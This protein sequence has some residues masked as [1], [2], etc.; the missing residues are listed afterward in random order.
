MPRAILSFVLALAVIAVVRAQTGAAYE[1]NLPAGFPRPYVPADNPMT[2][3]KAAL[4][5]YL[6]YDTRLSINGKVS[7]ATCHQQKLAFTDGR[8]V[9]EGATGEKH[10]RNSMTLVNV[11]WNATLTWGNPQMK[12]LEDQ[13]RVPMFGEHPL[14]M[15]LKNDAVYLPKLRADAQL[16][17]MFADAWPQDSDPITGDNVIR[18]IASFER[19]IISSGHSP[20]DRYHYGGD[21]TAIS[22]AAKHGESLFFN[23]HLS[24]FRCHGGFNFS[25]AT[26]SA[27]NPQRAV[28]FHNTGLYNLAGALSY[29]AANPGAFEFTQAAADIGKF[30]TPTLRNVAV[31]APYMHDG[32]MATLEEV[33]DSYAAGGRTI[34]S[35]PNAGIGKDNPHK[36]PLIHGFELSA[37]DRADLVAFLKTLTD[38]DLLNDPRF[39]DP[40]ISPLAR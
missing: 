23:Q 9:S 7:C 16:R 35:G 31:T 1:W 5:R 10:P 8:T 17:R 18:A 27:A 4:G 24:C 34:A 30:R 2:A 38:D 29:P 20:Y 39:N 21:D 22:A 28:E 32:S 40:R 6:F 13:A 26:N 14:E 33:L 11:A 36:D 19:T 25:D 15:G 37:Q 3:A 12:R